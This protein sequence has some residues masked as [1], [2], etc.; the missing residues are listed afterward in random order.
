MP[1]SVVIPILPRAD[2][3]HAALLRAKVDVG[4]VLR[5]MMGP[6]DAEE[7]FQREG[8]PAT[9]ASRILHRDA[10]TLAPAPAEQAVLRQDA[11][12]LALAA[13]PMRDAAAD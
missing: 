2:R 8:V 3:R 12:A 1:R 11:G 9:V 6:V 7:Y 4:I 13:A 5:D 10:V